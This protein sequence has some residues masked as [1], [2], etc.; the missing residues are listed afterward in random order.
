MIDRETAMQGIEALGT[1]I[2]ALLE[3]A[4]EAAVTPAQSPAAYLQS[5]VQL[6]GAGDDIAILAAAMRVLSARAETSE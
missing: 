3:G 5:A 2:A 4:H 6:G 1:A